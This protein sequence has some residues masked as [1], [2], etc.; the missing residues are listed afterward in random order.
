M[1]VTPRMCVWKVAAWCCGLPAVVSA[2]PIPIVNGSFEL[3]GTSAFTNDSPSGWTRAGSGGGVWNINNAPGN[4]WSAPAPDGNQI[5]WLARAD[6]SGVATC[7]QILSSN[8]EANTLYT[9]TGFAGHPIGFQTTYSV[10]LLAGG[11][12]LATHSSIGPAG[13]LT[14]FSVMFDS[15]GSLLVGQPL[16]IRL[17]SNGPQTGFDDIRLDAI[18]VPAPAAA[19]LVGCSA[20]LNSRR[21]RY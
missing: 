15:T 21:R 5:A 4:F 10:T 7:T 16:S 2:S 19:G 9:L 8:L 20:V 18:P 12:P 3:P 17:Q 1:N 14:S 11:D 6:S 13:S